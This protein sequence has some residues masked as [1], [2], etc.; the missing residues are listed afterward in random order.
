MAVSPCSLL[1]VIFLVF[2]ASSLSA[3]NIAGAILG[4][5]T[6]RS[7]AS[8]SNAPVTIT[9]TD[10]N[11]STRVT[12]N[13]AGAYEAP[14]LAP[15]SYAIQVAV[16]GFKT[17][18]RRHIQLEVEKQLRLDFALEV[19]DTSTSITVN[20][21]APLV[22]SESGSLGQVV[23]G[24]QIQDLPIKGQNIFDLA[25]LA[26]GVNVN[27][28]ALGGVASAGSSSAPLFVMS[29]MSI[30]G[31]RYRTNEFLLDGVSIMLPENNNFAVSPTP[32]GTQEFKV[33][34]N[35]YGP[36]FGRSGGGV[37]NVVTRGGTNK[38]HGTAYEFFRNDWF[39]ADNYFA[40]ASRQ[41]QQPQ[42]FDLFGG[43]VGAPIVRNKTFVFAEYQ[44][45]RSTSAL[46]GQF[47]TLPTEAERN[48]DFSHLLNSNGQPIGIYNPHNTLVANGVTLRVQFPNNQ[49][50]ISL[51]DPVA[52][53]MLTYI[54]LPNSAGIGPAG[55]NNYVWAQQ[56]FINSDQWSVRI[57]HRF[58]DRQMLFGR[59]TR[60]TGDSGKPGLSTTPQTTCSA[61]ISITS[62]T[63]FSTIRS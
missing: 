52:L 36:Q 42:H 7:G 50:P 34:T 20:G 48:G 1:V 28:A 35:S 6:D 17:A 8:M 45:N 59:F 51:T 54:P 60:N 13:A 47:A 40:N 33:M 12:T 57:D 4:T 18:I 23:E 56:A 9:N 14:Q 27:P 19:G 21:E 11:Q 22:D 3:Q 29:D 25:G 2:A 24:K 63:V 49:I 53:K 39:K 5:V 38:V 15:G 31:G 10:T 46:G 30:N 55:V 32:D 26:P 58:S 62:S 16:A 37:L 61:S 44:G 43:S 41:K